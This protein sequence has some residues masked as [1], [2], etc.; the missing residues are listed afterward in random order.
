MVE[1]VKVEL[2]EG[3]G[4]VVLNR[5]SALNAIDGDLMVSLRSGITR[6]T[7]DPA[8]KVIVISGEG[9]AFCAGADLTYLHDVLADNARYFAFV[10]ELNELF[11]LIEEA[12]LPTIAMVHDLA[13]AGGL[14]LL[15]ACDFAVA[16]ASARIGDQH[17]N[18]GLMPGGGSTQRL[19]RRV[20]VQRAKEMLFAADWITGVRAAEIGLVL[21]AVADDELERQ[22]RALAERFV[23]KSRRCTAMTK[24]AVER[25]LHLPMRDALRQETHALIEYFTSSRS[26]Q[27]GLQ[28]FR[29]RVTP[30][31]PE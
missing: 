24:R 15:L 27:V 14:E 8:C 22:T 21:Y 1:L 18:Y 17:A 7:E 6:L 29:D 26:P 16:A 20:G 13:L 12:P 19:P 2:A 4:R 11:L 3:I 23:G 28:A 31:F 10:H 25:G 9:R 5:P 30:E